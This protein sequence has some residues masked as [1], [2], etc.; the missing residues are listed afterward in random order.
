MQ[1]INKEIK[2]PVVR[3]HGG[4][5]KLAEWIVSYFPDHRIYVE[6]FGGGGS[7]LMRKTPSYAEV[8]NDIWD[9][10]VHVFACLRNPQLSK[11]LQESIRLTPFS[12]TEFENAGYSTDPIEKA[13]EIIYRSFSG[14][15][16]CAVDTKKP[17]GFRANSNRSGTTPAHDWKNYAKHITEFSERLRGVVI[18]NRDALEVMSQHDSKD[19]LHYV[20][21]PYIKESRSAGMRSKEYAHE[22][23]DSG[24]CDKEWHKHLKEFLDGLSGMVVL[25][26]Y[27]SNYY[28]SLFADWTR[29]D[30]EALADGAKKRVESIWLNAEANEKQQQKEMF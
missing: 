21:P 6:P 24:V 14:F 30:R 25:S 1:N 2:R 17:T 20:D 28:D 8:Y 13:R 11:L 12:R 22:V 9:E 5:W 27:R 4:K 18:E 15:G 29:H 3:Y 10:I 19:A 26:G 23:S 16:S 7:V